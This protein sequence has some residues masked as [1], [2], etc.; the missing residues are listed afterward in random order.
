MTKHIMTLIITVALIRL[1]P[2]LITGIPYHTDTYALL[3]LMDLLNVKTPTHLTPDD[4]FDNYNI[5]WPGIITYSVVHSVVVG[6]VPRTL[7]PIT[8]P[9]I[10]SLS[11]LPLIAFLRSLGASRTHSLVTT[12]IY[13]LV[14]TEVI[15]GAGVTKEGYALTLLMVLLLLNAL[16]FK[17]YT[18]SAYLALIT[19][20]AL[21]ITHH[22]TSVIG[23][24]L[25][26]FT[27]IAYLVGE[28]VVRRL[29]IAL[30]VQVV[31]TALLIIYIYTYSGR[32]LS[33]LA[34]M[35][36][37][38]IISL[39]AYEVTMTLP[40]LFSVMM[41]SW[42]NSMIKVWFLGAYALVVILAILGTKVE[43][44]LGAPRISTTELA[45]FTPY[46]I[47]ALLSIAYVGRL[48]R[49]CLNVFAYL[50]ILGLLGVEA[51]FIF[52]T[53]GLISE[54]YRTSTFMYLG[55][56]ILAAYATLAV[57]G[58]YKAYVMRLTIAVALITSA[59]LVPYVA[60]Y[61]SH[62]GGSQRIYLPSDLSTANY[63]SRYGG[64]EMFCG[65]LRF[66][67]LFYPKRVDTYGGLKYL[68]R[69]LPPNC[70]LVVNELVVD[71]GYVASAYGVPVSINN[72]LDDPIIYIGG[73]NF[74]VIPK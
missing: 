64:D 15:L 25:T 7:T 48:G 1:L 10:N 40:I 62:I 70:Y 71:V 22:L 23:L 65:D 11:I 16:I 35:G 3:P 29:T 31:S 47:I 36:V 9:I 42:L 74:I 43:L 56:S 51:Y 8:V 12:F 34:M 68:L 17:G 73:R 21:I 6:M 28:V 55:V 38:D 26:A 44:A 18:Q 2:Y 4:G 57:K 14:G 20:L 72:A 58:R 46:L 54:A 39:I 66:S 41:R 59:C 19:Y 50:V 32:G 52:G 33:I 5:Y 37:S 69:G 24:L 27:L 67:Y 13:G 30:A 60:F 53:P 63:I 61:S 49:T 45:F